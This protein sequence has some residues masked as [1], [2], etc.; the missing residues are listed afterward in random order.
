MLVG[1]FRWLTTPPGKARP[2]IGRHW[3][4]RRSSIS[5]CYAH[6]SLLRYAESSTETL[7]LALISGR[8]LR[9]LLQHADPKK[10]LYITP[11][12]DIDAQL[13]NENAS[14]DVRLG[15]TFLDAERGNTPFMDIVDRSAVDSA[16]KVDQFP[17]EKLTTRGQH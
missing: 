16:A 9:G 10:R 3:I 7:K 13:S 17:P 4:V 14:V 2:G 12:L 6:W 11:L 1:H 5:C 8:Q 15:S